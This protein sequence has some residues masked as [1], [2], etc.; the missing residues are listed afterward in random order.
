MAAH[1][2][3]I[4]YEVFGAQ[5]RPLETEY[6]EILGIK[7]DA[8]TE[9]VKE[10]YH[11]PNAGEMTLS[12]PVLRK[13]YNEFGSRESQPEG[14]FADP[15]EFL[16]EDAASGSGGPKRV[17]SSKDMTPEEKAQ[18]DE[19]RRKE[20]AERAAV[21]EERVGKLVEELERKLSIFTE[22]VTGVDDKEITLSWRSIC[23]LEAEQL[24][25]ESYGVE[26]LH[27]IGFVYGDIQ[28]ILFK[29][30]ML[31]CPDKMLGYMRVRHLEM[32]K[33]CAMSEKVSLFRSDQQN[34]FHFLGCYVN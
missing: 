24:R 11:D 31:P 12:D 29:S 10:A 23:E 16:N 7:I 32:E 27:S 17:K 19:K 25:D 26:L 34:V 30:P 5:E 1:H 18:R 14:G 9:E 13:K 2:P 22:S 28:D 20:A 8:T 3:N 6:Y 21:R 4:M 15:E 33:E